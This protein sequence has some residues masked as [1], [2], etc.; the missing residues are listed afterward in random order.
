MADMKKFLLLVLLPGCATLGSAIRTVEDIA[1]AECSAWYSA[2][3][4]ISIEDAWK[5]F[6]AAEE[7]WGPFVARVE[8]EEREGRDGVP[9]KTA[10]VPGDCSEI[11][12]DGGAP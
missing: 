3:Q 2:H 9:L 4:G 5:D 1:R 8:L 7:H 12:V 6:C 10:A 11:W